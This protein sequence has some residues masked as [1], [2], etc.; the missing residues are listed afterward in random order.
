MGDKCLL[1]SQINLTPQH[2]HT[3]KYYDTCSTPVSSKL[4]SV[5][6]LTSNVLFATCWHYRSYVALLATSSCALAAFLIL[7]AVN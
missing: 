3:E 1:F 7:T 5:G 6:F 4:R 2:L